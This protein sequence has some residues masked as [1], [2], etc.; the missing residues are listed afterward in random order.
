MKSKKSINIP[1]EILADCQ[2]DTEDALTVC[3]GANALVILPERMNALETANAIAVLNEITVELICALEKACSPCLTRIDEEE[4]PYREPDSPGR[5]PFAEAAPVAVS[6]SVREAMG[7]S[8]DTKLCHFVDDGELVVTA[9]EYDHDITDVPEDIL[10][11]LSMAGICRGAL[12]EL[13]IEGT[14]VWHG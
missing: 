13:I 11:V 3:T 2:L 4:C 10:D 9:A 12:N 6:D 8:P 14:E 1:D 5:C 7:V